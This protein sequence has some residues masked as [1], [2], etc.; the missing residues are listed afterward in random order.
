MDDFILGDSVKGVSAETIALVA[1]D[2]HSGFVSAIPDGSSDWVHSADGLG[3]HYGQI[4]C[5]ARGFLVY[6]DSAPAYQKMCRRLQI[7]HRPATPTH[8]LDNVALHAYP[9]ADLAG[10]YDTSKA[11]S[12]R[13]LEIRG[14]NTYFPLGWYSKRQSATN[15]S[16]TEA[17]LVSA[18]KMQ[19]ESLVPIQHLWSIVLQRPM[20]AIIHKDNQSTITVIESGYSPQL[21]HL[22]EHHRISLGLVSELCKK[23]DIH[24]E[25]IETDKQKGDILTKGLQRPKHEPASEM[26]P[27]LVLGSDTSIPTMCLV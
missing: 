10:T 9:D 7:L 23:P 21:R 27:C 3:Q 4:I 15:H 2:E 11:T 16:T 13:C 5:D 6:S 12:G 25:H 1:R 18:S 24:L 8:D 17:E 20:H 19:R 14:N 26:I 22:A